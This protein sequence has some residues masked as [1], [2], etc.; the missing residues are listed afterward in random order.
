MKKLIVLLTVLV[1]TA[2]T[3]VMV[4]DGCTYNHPVRLCP[5]CHGTG[6]IRTSIGQRSDRY[7]RYRFRYCNS[8]RGTGRIHANRVYRR[9]L[10]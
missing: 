9:Y 10:Y 7:Y 2:C 5:V 8:C 3:G 1:L 4:Y 6:R